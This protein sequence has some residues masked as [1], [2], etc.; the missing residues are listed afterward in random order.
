MSKNLITKWGNRKKNSWELEMRGINNIVPASHKVNPTGLYGD[1]TFPQKRNHRKKR[2]I[3][4]KSMKTTKRRS[5]WDDSDVNGK[6]VMKSLLRTIFPHTL[7][8]R[9]DLATESRSLGQKERHICSLPSSLQSLWIVLRLQLL[10]LISCYHHGD[11]LLFLN[12]VWTSTSPL[13]S[14]SSK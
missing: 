6:D 2:K 1:N 5:G 12:P 9:T 3:L 8:K 11:L 13:A 10:G 7:D 4:M 14:L